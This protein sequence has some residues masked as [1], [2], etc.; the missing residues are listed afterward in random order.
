MSTGTT[1]LIVA[2]IVV[3]AI[4]ALVAALRARKNRQA[5]SG[6]GLPALGA[7]SIEEPSSGTADPDPRVQKH[8]SSDPVNR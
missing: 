1:V 6:I 4:V 2:V 8:S 5:S 7:L 3:I